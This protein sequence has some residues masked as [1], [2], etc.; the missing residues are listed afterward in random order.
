MP[1]NTPLALI[2][3]DGYGIAAPSPGNAIGQATKPNFDRFEREYPAITL[4]ASGI[5]VGQMW[6]A[7]GNSETGHLNIGSG[8][9]VYQQLP[10]ILFAIREGA[11]Y[12]NPALLEACSWVKQHGGT[13]HLAGLLSTG[14]VHSYIDHLY[15]LLDLA[16]REHVPRVVLHL[17]LDGR[18]SFIHEAKKFVQTLQQRL[19]AIHLGEIGTIMGRHFAMDRNENWDR[20]QCA[21]ACMTEGVGRK[22]TDISAYIE[23]NYALGLTDEFIEPAVAVDE[24]GR[25]SGTVQQ[26]DALIFFNFRSER[27]RQITAA[28]AEHDFL[29]FPRPLIPNLKVVTMSEYEPDLPLPVAFPTEDI[30]DTLPEVLSREKFRQLHIAETEKYAHIT[31]FFNGRREVPFPGEDRILI[32]SQRVGSFADNPEMQAP[33]ICTRVIDKIRHGLYEV[34]IINFANPDMVGHTGNISATSKAVEETDRAVG[35]ICDAILAAGGIALVTGDHGNCEQMIDLVNNAPRREH[36]SNPVPCFLVGNNYLRKSPGAPLTAQLA[37]R[38]RLA[39]IAPTVLAL[40]GIHQPKAM[41]GKNLLP[42][43][44]SS[45]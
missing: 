40:L 6:G 28:F 32:P 45:E 34:Y 35:M 20:T 15:A 26:N 43:L 23:A 31:Y 2:V 42:I 37:P 30:T 33:E 29:H 41:T 9:V 22:I 14:T 39:D 3:V 13:L 27:M 10:R 16:K 19:A 7:V 5:D 38:G 44:T 1:R 25:S 18:D 12:K 8:R 4:S 17:W 21:Y 11:F 36:T 24:F